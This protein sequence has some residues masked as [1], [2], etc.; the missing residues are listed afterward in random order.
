MV[1]LA[2][3]FGAVWNYPC[4]GFKMTG[5][6]DPNQ[7]GRCHIQV[8][9]DCADDFVTPAFSGRKPYY[10]QRT[11]V[12]YWYS[13]K[14]PTSSR[15]DTGDAAGWDTPNFHP[16]WIFG[17]IINRSGSP[18]PPAA[19]PDKDR[20]HEYA[21]ANFKSL[22]EGLQQVSSGESGSWKSGEYSITLPGK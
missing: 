19:S 3:D 22:V 5:T 13:G 14:N 1:N 4:D 2:K 21:D 8:V 20:H 11:R 7:P 9:L 12:S 15:K 16:W 10:D 17:P 6:P 18:A